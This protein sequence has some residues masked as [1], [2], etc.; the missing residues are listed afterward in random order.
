MHQ[1]NF[2]G[3]FGLNGDGDHGDGDTSPPAGSLM[4][5]VLAPAEV[6]RGQ[7]R[8]P[9]GR[10]RAPAAPLAGTAGGATFPCR[11]RPAPRIRSIG[12]LRPLLGSPQMSPRCE[13]V[14]AAL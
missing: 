12:G 1:H 5:A 2:G 4:L 3:W 7:P 13:K 10:R 8:R 9:A 6:P 11:R 14:K